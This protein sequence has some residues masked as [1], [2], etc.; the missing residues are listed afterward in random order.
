M[1]LATADFETTTDINECRVWAW[2]ICN[3]ND[4]EDKIYGNSLDSF[5]ETVSKMKNLTLYFHNLKFDGEFIIKGLFDKGFEWVKDRKD[6]VNNKFTTLIS[7]KGQFYSMELQINS[8]RIKIYDSLKILPFSISEIA[9]AFKLPICKLEIDY[10]E[11]REIGHQLTPQEMA[12]I[13]NDAEIAARG[14]KVLFDQGLNKMTQGSNALFD[15]KNII[16]KKRF[17]RDFPIP[18]YDHDIRQSYKGGFTYVNP[19]FQKPGIG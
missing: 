11:T 7:D 4:V 15:Y 19:R 6:I 8:N 1:K 10:H 14:L 18:L 12:Y 13:A 5:F 2:V 9:E 17:E 3:I 16:G